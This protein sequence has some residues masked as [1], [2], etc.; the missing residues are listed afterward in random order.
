MQ[1]MIESLGKCGLQQ[2][3]KHCVNEHDEGNFAMSMM[4]RGSITV[5]ARSEAT[6]QSSFSFLA[7]LWIAASLRSSQ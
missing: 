4:T 3:R 2:S 1:G 5:I 7:A 6:K